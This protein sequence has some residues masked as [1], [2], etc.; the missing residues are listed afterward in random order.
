MLP[1]RLPY[2]HWALSCTHVHNEARGRMLHLWACALLWQAA[3]HAVLGQIR[4]AVQ[5]DMT[6]K[7]LWTLSQ[8]VIAYIPGSDRLHAITWTTAL[9]W[10]EVWQCI[11]LSYMPRYDT[12]D[13]PTVLGSHRSSVSPASLLLMY[14]PPS[15]K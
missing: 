2:C 4:H 15:E 7:P 6:K 10:K 5:F 1:R 8:E 13:V 3:K 9:T 14:S 12:A 11:L